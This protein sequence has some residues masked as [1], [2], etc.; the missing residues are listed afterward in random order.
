MASNNESS[1]LSGASGSRRDTRN[2]VG[3][4]FDNV[5]EEKKSLEF[6]YTDM[7]AITKLTQVLDLI[8]QSGC[9]VEG[10]TLEQLLFYNRTDVNFKTM[11]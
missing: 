11:N 8:R 2:A 9:K 7:R 6:A 4:I 3:K 10:G 5:R 1:H